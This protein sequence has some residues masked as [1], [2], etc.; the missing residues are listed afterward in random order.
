MSGFVLLNDSLGGRSGL[1]LS[2]EWIAEC[3]M[4]DVIWVSLSEMIIY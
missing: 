4:R 3:V 2:R 1:E